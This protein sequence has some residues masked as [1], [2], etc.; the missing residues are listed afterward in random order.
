MLRDGEG[1]RFL[2]RMSKAATQIL[3]RQA[4]QAIDAVGEAFGLPPGNWR[5]LLTA[6]RGQGLLISGTNRTGLES[7]ASDSEHALAPALS[8]PRCWPGIVI[9]T[10][11]DACGGLARRTCLLQ[12]TGPWCVRWRLLAPGW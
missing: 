11:G 10:A 3:L 4:P 1:A 7:I 2:F 9:E 5:L 12:W 6:R 8:R